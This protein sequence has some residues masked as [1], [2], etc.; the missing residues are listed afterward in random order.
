M[1]MGRK[2]LFYKKGD[3]IYKMNLYSLIVF[4]H[5]IAGVNLQFTTEK[6]VN[7]LNSS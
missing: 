6:E 1:S 4:H 2:L 5:F 7:S 3:G